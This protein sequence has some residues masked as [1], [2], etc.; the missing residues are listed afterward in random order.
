VVA[1]EAARKKNIILSNHGRR[2]VHDYFLSILCKSSIWFTE[3]H[4]F[5]IVI[6]FFDTSKCAAYCVISFKVYDGF[7][8][9]KILK[10]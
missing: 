7:I 1:L 6:Y 8:G 10:I 4:I 5:K 9:Q 3:K 2:K